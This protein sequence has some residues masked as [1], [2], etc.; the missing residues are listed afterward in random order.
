VQKLAIIG[1][2][3]HVKKN[4]LPAIS[5]V[6]DITIEAIYVRDPMKYIKHG[7]NDGHPIKSIEDKVSADVDWVY[8]ATPIATHFKFSEIYLTE[9]KNVICEKPLTDNAGKTLALLSLA[10][11]NKVQLYEV[12]MYQNHKQ[13]L[14][15]KRSILDNFASLKCVHSVFTVPHFE[16]N[17][18][19][20]N[21]NLSGGALLDVGYYPISLIVSLFGEPKDIQSINY[22]NAGFNV[23]L[24]GSA[25]FIYD[26]F[27]CIA[28]WGI[29]LPY[30]N[31]TIIVTENQTITYN[32]CFSKTKKIITEASIF[33]TIENNNKT[34]TIG[35]DDQ[36]ANMFTN[37]VVNNKVDLAASI[38]TINTIKS[39]TS[40]KDL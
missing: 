23:D 3:D 35:Q 25:M 24:F 26:H 28:E 22:S 39:I 18:I 32:R 2:G 10:K 31:N 38:D 21:K 29:G 17:N 30:A 7:K 12:C 11:K 9:G 34:I 4:I 27:Y 20:Y 15:L 33:N 19:R 14:H 13:F 37:I 16:E 5:R 8:I 6:S 40:I 1:Y 36:F